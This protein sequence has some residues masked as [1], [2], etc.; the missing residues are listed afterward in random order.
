MYVYNLIITHSRN[1]LHVFAWAE[2]YGLN[3]KTPSMHVNQAMPGYQFGVFLFMYVY[4]FIITYSRNKLHLFAWAE[5]YG[6][7]YKAPSI[8]VNQ[9]MSGLSVR[10]VS[11]DPRHQESTQ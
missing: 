8:H 11:F 1:K 4:N 7:N 6:L 5:T 3:Y 2:T 9:A 10:C